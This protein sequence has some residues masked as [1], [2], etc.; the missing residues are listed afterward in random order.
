M[1]SYEVLSG[2]AAAALIFGWLYYQEYQRHKRTDELARD[3]TSFYVSQVATCEPNEPI[4]WI[5]ECCNTFVIFNQVR[6]Q[7][8]DFYLMEDEVIKARITIPHQKINAVLNCF[9]NS[10]CPIQDFDPTEF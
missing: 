7:G 2:V 10:G 4:L 6:Q 3:A 8:F 5:Y 1:V 9:E